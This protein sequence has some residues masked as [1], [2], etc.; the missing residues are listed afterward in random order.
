MN[1]AD[2]V[3]RSFSGRRT[4]VGGLCSNEN[5]DGIDVAKIMVVEDEGI[6]SLDLQLQLMGL[7]Y[8]VSA[9]AASGEEA[10]RKATEMRPDL[11]LMDIR[12]K[13]DVD[14]IEAAAEIHTRFN[15]PVIYLTALADQDTVQRSEMTQHYGYVTKPLEEAELHTAI[16]A[17]LHRHRAACKPGGSDA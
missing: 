15:I 6:V 10:I 17:A 4:P 16:E 11:V 12:L 1:T 13:G 3:L 5:E 9:V 7:G 2:C 8:T 14:G